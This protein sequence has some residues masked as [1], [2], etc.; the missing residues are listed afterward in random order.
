METALYPYR[1]YRCRFFRAP[2][3]RNLPPSS[4]GVGERVPCQCNSHQ[5]HRVGVYVDF[6][7]RG[8]LWT[9]CSFIWRAN[10][11]L[12]IFSLYFGLVSQIGRV[13]GR[14]I[15]FPSQSTSARTSSSLLFPPTMARWYFC[16]LFRRLA[17]RLWCLWVPVPLQMY[18][19]PF[20]NP[21]VGPDTTSDNRTKTACIRHVHLPYRAPVRPCSRSRS[22]RCAGRGKLAVDFRVSRCGSPWTLTLFTPT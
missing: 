16:E 8:K 18:V 6:R 10:L 7:V 14:S 15:S 9:A 19:P 12:C 13:A 17:L 5:H 3:R 2:S 22:R 11:T 4:A 1:H 21:V 20:P